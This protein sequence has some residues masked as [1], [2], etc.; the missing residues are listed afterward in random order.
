MGYRVCQATHSSAGL[1]RAYMQ[2]FRKILAKLRETDKQS[3]P[4]LH[5]QFVLDLQACLE[6]LI[7]DSHQIILSI[8]SNEELEVPPIVI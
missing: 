6:H 5:C 7:K 1:K 4:N 8:N 2:Q 3:I